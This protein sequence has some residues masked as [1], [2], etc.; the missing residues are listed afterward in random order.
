MADNFRENF[1]SPKLWTPKSP[2]IALYTPGLPGRVWGVLCGNGSH[3]IVF[4]VFWGVVLVI[5][6]CRVNQWPYLRGGGI[7]FFTNQFAMS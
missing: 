7:F 3:Q 6:L 5:L 2:G 1:I 4:S